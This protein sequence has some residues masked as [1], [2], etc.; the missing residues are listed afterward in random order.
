MATA[1]RT[2]SQ[3]FTARIEYDEAFLRD[4]LNGN[5]ECKRIGK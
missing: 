4:L 2:S 3:P 1:R 5:V